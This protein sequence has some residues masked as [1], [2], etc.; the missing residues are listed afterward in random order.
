MRSII[1]AK[2]TWREISDKTRTNCLYT[3]TIRAERND[4]GNETNVDT[5]SKMLKF[6]VNPKEKAYSGEESVQELADYKKRDFIVYDNI[7]KRKWT[8]KP[9][10]VRQIKT[11]IKDKQGRIRPIKNLHGVKDEHGLSFPTIN[12]WTE[13]TLYSHEIQHGLQAKMYEYE[14]LDGIEFKKGKVMKSFIEKTYKIKRDAEAEGNKVCVAIGAA[15]SSRSRCKLW[16]LMNDIERAGGEIF[17]CDTDSVMTDYKLEDDER[18]MERYCWDGNG[19]ALGSL[20]N[21]AGDFNSD[22]FDEGYIAGKKNYILRCGDK[23]KSSCKGFTFQEKDKKQ[24]LNGNEVTI[25][26]YINE[27]IEGEQLRMNC[28][29]S[30]FV[31]ETD[32]FVVSFAKVPKVIKTKY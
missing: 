15:I 8:I 12:N 14:V 10:K 24:Y 16:R 29:K 21:E 1:T 31:S 19:K 18:L 2:A 13:M 26:T 25:D 5:A 4:K 3:A 23:H 20:K 27:E 17:Y 9:K 22:H 32:P 28:S 7:Y 6:K 30:N 11:T